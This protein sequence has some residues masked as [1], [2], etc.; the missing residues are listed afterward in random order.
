M[1]R[2]R[3][4]SVRRTVRAT[5]GTLGAFAVVAA[6]TLAL[7]T[8][9]AWEDRG[10]T[11]VPVFSAENPPPPIDDDLPITA[12]ADTELASEDPTEWVWTTTEGAQGPGPKNFCVALGV[13]TTTD[14]PSPWELV[15]HLSEPPWD[16]TA[17]FTDGMLTIWFSPP[18]LLE[19]DQ[20]FAEN[21]LVYLRAGNASAHWASKTSQY[22]VRLCANTGTPAWQPPGTDTYE[23][24]ETTLKVTAD[25]RPEVSLRI[26][27]R[28]WY[29]IGYTATFNWRDLL[30]RELDLT[31]ITQEQYDAWLPIVN[32][33]GTASGQT[34]ANY[35]VT[36]TPYN[37]FDTF[38]SD[39]ADV[40]LTVVGNPN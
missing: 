14:E 11:H 6:A 4:D 28:T 33:Y 19:K 31:N 20:N 37:E 21:G 23:I 26:T 27:G 22:T 32:W 29:F 34:G 15:L 1:S 7:P 5:I 2:Q 8:I 9:A 16:W 13:T 17:P 36:V 12:G 10:R 39:Q 40:A 3:N 38:I 18:F 24:T 30:D 25:N 35:N